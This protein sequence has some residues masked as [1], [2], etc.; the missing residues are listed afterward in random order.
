LTAEANG[1]A[2][3]VD[4]LGDLVLTR[5]AGI[6]TVTLNAPGRRNA[7]DRAMARGLI[8]ACEELDADPS[9]GAVIVQGADGYFCSGGER[10]M[11]DAVG[12]SPVGPDEFATMTDVYA[13]FRRV[14]ALEAPTIAAI[15]GGAVGAGLNLAMATDLRIVGRDALLMSGFMRLGLQPGGGHGLLLSAS[16]GLE[17]TAALALFDGRM[18][19]ERAAQLGFAWE[20]VAD[21]EVESSAREMAALPARDPEL[22]RGTA[23]TI[24]MQI[25]AR[26]QA[27]DG[28]LELERVGQAWSMYRRYLTDVAAVRD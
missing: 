28:A 27:W 6:A 1:P 7:I 18:T 2:A 15:R 23:R 25:P 5:E 12:R 16:G 19:G 10:E 20:A 26:T 14:G 21:E 17:A 24:R 11:L 3:R 9:V 22:A 4:R 13:S 8:E